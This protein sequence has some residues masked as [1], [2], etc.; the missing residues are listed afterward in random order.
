MPATHY[1][2]A[3]QR[4]IETLY[5]G[6]E[7]VSRQR[8]HRSRS[9]SLQRGQFQERRQ[10]LLSQNRYDDSRSQIQLLRSRYDQRDTQGS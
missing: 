4:E 7:S 5:M 10:R 8:F 1:T 2:E 9:R 3:E 6:R